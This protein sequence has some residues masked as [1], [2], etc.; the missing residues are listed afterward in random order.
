VHTAFNHHKPERD[1]MKLDLDLCIVRSFHIDDAVSIA[2]LANNRKIWIN[3]RDAFPHPYT[4]NDAISFIG[5][6]KSQKPE[7]VFTIEVDSEACGA[8]G[9]H[10]GKDVERISA[11]IGYWLA[12]PL[13][14]RGI[15]TE[16][17][18]AVTGYA[19]ENFALERIFA[20]PYAW[21]SA[22]FRVLEKCGYQLEGRMRRSAIKD[23]KVVDQLLYAYIR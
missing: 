3:L 9:F 12:E 2:R 10:P 5:M 4:I 6:V 18:D 20:L 7:T 16:V 8:I 13:W 19:M 1:V 17:L 21:N 11:E 22:S 14:G 15:M 23:G